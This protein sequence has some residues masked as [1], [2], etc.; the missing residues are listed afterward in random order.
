MKL[1]FAPMMI[2]MLALAGASPAA[3]QSKT[4]SDQS[5]SVGTSATRDAATERSS[6]AHQAQDEVQVWQQKL[7][8]FDA[9]VRVKATETE[10]SASKRFG[11]RVG[12]NPDGVQPAGDGR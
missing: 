2:G 4:E 6:Y 8:D 9:K 7:H 1:F 10:A 5:T 12:R 3:A 11:Q